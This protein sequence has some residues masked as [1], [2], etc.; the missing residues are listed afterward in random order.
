MN[1][2]FKLLIVLFALPNHSLS[3]QSQ[4]NAGKKTQNK[5]VATPKPKPTSPS[6]Q[7]IFNLKMQMPRPLSMAQ[8]V[9][10]MGS[11]F[12]GNPYPKANADTSRRTVTGQVVLQ[13]IQKE[14]LVVNLKKFDCVTFVESMIAL[15]QTQRDSFKSFDLFKKKLTQVRYRNAQIDYAARLHYFSDW[16]YENEQHGILT[17]ITKDIGGERFH[18]IVNYMSTKRDTFYGNMADPTTFNTMKEIEKNITL[19]EKWYIPKEKVAA[20]ESKLK[21][22]D[23][24][25]IT[26]ITEGMDMAH[27]GIVI[28]VSGRAHLLHASSQFQQVVISDVP[29]VDYLKRNKLQTGIMVG[30]LK[31]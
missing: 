11:T 30:R 28:F 19:R 22:G 16:L 5:T 12:I 7:D 24:I 26:N 1:H 6:H 2:F 9:V 8:G 29:L 18:K 17:N 10:A 13:P 3:A 23:I 25:G 20:I 4:A 15:T 21:E 31:E 27:A 14:V